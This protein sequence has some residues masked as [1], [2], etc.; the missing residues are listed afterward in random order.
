MAALTLSAAVAGGSCS[1]IRITVQPAV[2]S[3]VSES[4]A[5]LPSIFVLQNSEFRLAGRW[6]SRQPCQKQPST[7]TAT[8]ALGNNE[9]S[10]PAD[11]WQGADTDSVSQAEGVNRGPDREF[12]PGLAALVTLHNRPHGRR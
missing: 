8:L 10:G 11:P 3:R 9:V 1:H 12:G 6:C 7:K 2:R 4:R 5:M